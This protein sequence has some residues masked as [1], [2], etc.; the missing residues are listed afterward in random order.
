MLSV[1]DLT[2][3]NGLVHSKTFY[4]DRIILV[5][6]N[7]Y[8]NICNYLMYFFSSQWFCALF[9]KLLHNFCDI[10]QVIV[11]IQEWQ[12][13]KLILKTIIACRSISLCTFFHK[14]CVRVN[15]CNYIPPSTLKFYTLIDILVNFLQELIF[16]ILFSMKH[17]RKMACK[18]TAF[19]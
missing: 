10:L 12:V 7:S 2:F 13:R 9:R 18:W 4:N 14:M 11:C 15:V 19:N 6:F 16:L 5:Y 1:S 17:G 8:P 3:S